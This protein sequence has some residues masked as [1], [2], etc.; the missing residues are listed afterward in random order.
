MNRSQFQRAIGVAYSTILNWERGRT[1]PNAQH[2]QL[3]SQVTGVPVSE[4]LG[5]GAEPDEPR[6]PPGY[7]AL[8]KFLASQAGTRI[9]QGER[10]TLENMIFHDIVPSEATFHAVLVGLRMGAG[11]V[12]PPQTA[13]NRGGDGRSR[14][15]DTSGSRSNKKRTSNRRRR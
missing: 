1:R 9:T 4:L 3:I 15:R 6:R 5:A 13:R 14:V 2:L 12:G 10:K 7:P 11:D 8:G